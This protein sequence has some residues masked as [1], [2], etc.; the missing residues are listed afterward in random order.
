MGLTAA[1]HPFS[2]PSISASSSR[3]NARL[4]RAFTLSSN[5]AMLLA[6][7]RTL[8]TSFL[9]STQARAIRARDCPRSPATLSRALIL[10]SLS[11]VRYLPPIVEP[12]FDA[13]E[14][15]GIPF[16]YLPVRAPC[17]RGLYHMQPTPSRSRSSR[18]PSSAQRSNIIGDP[19]IHGL[20]LAHDVRQGAHVLLQGRLRVRTMMVKHIHILQSHTL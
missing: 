18:R 10:T 13:L 16:R 17:S 20:S 5:W 15:S 8:V 2:M 11:S 12:F 6:P 4:S 9:R 1:C 19:H 3:L 14:P 7:M